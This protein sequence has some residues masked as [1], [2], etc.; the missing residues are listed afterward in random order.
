MKNV[1]I[2]IDGSENSLRA[3]NYMIEHVREYGPCTIH[4]LNVQ[5][6]IV[7]G[8]VRAFISKEMIQDYYDDESKA[9]LNEAKAALDKAGVMYQPAMRVGQ[10]ATTITAYATEQGCDHIVMGSRG[11]GAAGSLLLGSV[12]L[13]V[14]HTTHVPVVLIN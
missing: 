13:K 6:P 14:L 3:V 12:A 10:I 5:M 4:L 8:T 1:L 9:A 2:P 7:S 11:L